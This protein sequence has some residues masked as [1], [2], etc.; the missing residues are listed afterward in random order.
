MS[1]SY[2]SGPFVREID[3]K[4]P[5]A[6][7]IFRKRVDTGYLRLYGFHLLAGR[8]LRPSD[9]INEDML[10]EPAVRALGFNSPQEAV[11][12]FLAARG[13]AQLPIVGVVKDFHSQNFY[14]AIDPIV[15]MMDHS[16]LSTLNIKLEGAPRSWQATLKTVERQ[17]NGF[18]PAGSFSYK[19]YDETIA[20][21]Y[22]D[23]E[24]MAKLV[25]LTTAVA[26]FISC[27]GLFGLAVLTAYQR[28]K[29]IGIRKVLGASVASIV[30][31]LSREYVQLVGLAI[32][33]STPLTWWAAHRWLLAVCGRGAR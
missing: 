11:G 17:W 27:L 29:E 12:Q 24:H 25:N 22:K 21:L 14:A 20:A 3:G 32:V 8:N 7:N 4:E 30:G 33:I 5:I 16:N 31:L 13:G 1:S 18:Y 9:T 23:E 10:N 6:R 19:F 26:I 2:N 15:I 28:T